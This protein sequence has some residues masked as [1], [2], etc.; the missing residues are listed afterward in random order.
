MLADE[1]A[2]AVLLALAGSGNSQSEIRVYAQRAHLLPFPLNPLYKVN[3]F[4]ALR[5]V[6]HSGQRDAQ[7]SVFPCAA[8]WHRAARF[9]GG[10]DRGEQLVERA[11]Y[12]RK[13]EHYTATIG[14]AARGRPHAG[15]IV[16]LATNSQSYSL[17]VT[18]C[19]CVCMCV[20]VFVLPVVQLLHH[21]YVSVAV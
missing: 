12:Q 19:V 13:R 17:S 2:G 16:G 9:R 15:A 8:R 14:S 20:C 21:L 4:S 1:A 7:Y 3:A 18:L 11:G 5:Q 6:P 10:L